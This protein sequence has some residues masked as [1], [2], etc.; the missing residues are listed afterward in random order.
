MA[1]LTITT[2]RLQEIMPLIEVAIDREIK[3]LQFGL[4]RKKSVAKE[5]RHT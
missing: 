5:N 2:D 3:H 1:A 4:E